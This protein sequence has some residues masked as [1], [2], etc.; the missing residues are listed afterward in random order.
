MVQ[1]DI[2]RCAGFTGSRRV[3]ALASAYN[4]AVAP[5]TGASG[6]VCIAATLHLAA[7]VPNLLTFEDM[8]IHN[9][10]HAILREPLPKQ[11]D[12]RIGVPL[13]PGLGVA[14][15]DESLARFGRGSWRV[16]GQDRG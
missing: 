7:A 4:V 6:P 1:P 8:Y 5:H 3:A 11:A 15:N 9:P 2:A 16:S 14:L 12:G 10:L 13:A